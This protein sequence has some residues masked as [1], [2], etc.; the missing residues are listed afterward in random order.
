MIKINLSLASLL[1]SLYILSS[2]NTYDEIITVVS[3]IPKEDYK[4]PSTVDVI[5]QKLLENTLQIDVLSILSNI[6]AIDTSSNGGPGQVS[7]IFIRGSSSNHSL[8]KINGVK[9]NP[10]TAGG[11][12]VYNLDT[13][14][15]S[16]IEI[17]SGPLSSIHGSEAIGGVVN[18]STRNNTLNDSM[19]LGL[20]Y[21]PDNHSKK[22]MQGNLTF[23]KTSLNIT[24]LNNNT[25]GFP[26]LRNSLIDRGYDNK[27]FVSDLSYNSKNLDASFSSWSSKGNVEYLVFNNPV[28]QDYINQ[29]Q[30]IEVSFKSIKDILL[31]LNI[32]SFEDLIIQNNPNYL[33]ILDLTKTKRNTYEVLIHKPNKERLSYSGGYVV[34]N[35]D[36]NYSSYGTLF[37]KGLQ[38]KAYF[39]TTEWQS[40]N[41]AFIGSIR[42]SFH[43]LHGSQLSWNIGFIKEL[44][45]NWFLSFSSGEAFRSPNSSELYGFGSNKELVPEASKSYEIGFSK[46]KK[47][48][49]LKI[50]LFKSNTLNLINYDFSDHIL[51][52]IEESTNHGLELR[53]KWNNNFS[54][55]S[56]LVRKQDP[57]DKDNNLLIRRSKKS[58]SL[59]ITKDIMGYS[60]GMNLSAF[61]KKN[62][63]GN[64]K[65]P[66]YFL[67]NL[68]AQKDINN[69][70]SFLL[71][72]ENFTN[73]N[74]F[75][76]ASSTSYYLNQDRS[77]WLKLNYKLR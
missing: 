56:L 23:N 20:I 59:N 28:A 54:Y 71:R 10:A 50:V 17:A 60:L 16:K 48:N 24:F 76:A 37:R 73:K 53:Y 62:D 74:Y 55:G 22:Y 34:E 14:L 11:A 41:N 30:A 77:L 46:R 61:G 36:V 51:K 45:T 58:A 43:D 7:S 40:S 63:F 32:N 38:T 31:I 72:I 1:F 18:I 44:N 12:S 19:K 21:G 33:G 3:K 42:K 68:T 5:D 9:I 70:L 39:G 47:N 13:N 66:G 75:T 49:N 35:E 26:V 25:N 15:I 2:A 64:H 52:N 6:L 29:A 69:K 8:V 27:S 4:V 67:I 57:K 65:L